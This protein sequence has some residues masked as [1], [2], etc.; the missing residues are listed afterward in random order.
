MSAEIGDDE[1]MKAMRVAGMDS[2]Q[3][4]ALTYTSWKDGIDIERPSTA[5]VA[6]VQAIHH[7]LC[8]PADGQSEQK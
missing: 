2:R 8:R 3:I 4:R 1:I 6:F 5:L 7:R